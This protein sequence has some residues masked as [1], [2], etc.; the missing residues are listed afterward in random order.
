MA[1]LVEPDSPDELSPRFLP[2]FVASLGWPHHVSPIND[3][4]ATLVQRMARENPNWGY[5]RIQGEL[6]KLG[7]RIGASTI[8]RIGRGQGAWTCSGSRVRATIAHG[9]RCSTRSS[10]AT[11]MSR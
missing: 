10:P 6:L 1:E 8:R 11:W 7:H 3:V 2:R 4:I 9:F 5:R